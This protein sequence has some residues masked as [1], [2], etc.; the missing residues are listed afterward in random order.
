MFLKLQIVISNMYPGMFLL[1]LPDKVFIFLFV[2]GS[3]L[4]A[5]AIHHIHWVFCLTNREYG[6]MMVEYLFFC[7]ALTLGSNLHAVETLVAALQWWH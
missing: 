3:A 4:V 5:P 2:F 7:C 1:S 6:M